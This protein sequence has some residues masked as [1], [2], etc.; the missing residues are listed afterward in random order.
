MPD[1]SNLSVLIIDPNQGMRASLHN[2]LTQ[3]GI[4]K[5]DHAVSSGTAIRQLGKKSYDVIL[6]E[7][8]LSS[9]ADNAGQDG[10]QLLEDLRHHKVIGQW[11]IFI[12]LTSEGV[13]GRVIGAAEL[14]PTDY[15]LKP[16]TVDTLSQRISRALERR[17]TF[18]PIY[19]MIGQGKAREAVTACINAEVAQP[20]YATDYVRL[21]AELLVSMGQVAAAE[22]AYAAVLQNKQLGWAQLG[23]ARCMFQ[24]KRYT[25]AQAALEA[26]LLQNPKFMAAYDL[27]AQVHRALGA[28]EDAKRVLRDAIAISPHMVR[29]LRN[30]GEVALAT[31]DVEGAEKAF[32]QVVAKAKYSEFRDPEDHVNLVKTL[33]TKGDA[34]GAA[35]VVRDLERSMR[36]SPNADVCRAYSAALVQEMNGNAEGAVAE[37]TTA[38]GALGEAKVSSALKLGLAQ[39]CMANELDEQANTLFAGLTSDP[40]SG[41]TDAQIMALCEK[42]GRADMAERYGAKVDSEVDQ[43][44]RK[45][46]EKSRQGDLRGAV[47][48]LQDALRRRPDNTGLWSA[49]ANAILRQ[50][51]DLGW[52]APLAAQ[53]AGLLKRMR[54]HN[55]DHPLLPSLISQYTALRQ[56]YAPQAS[57]NP[58][59]A[60]PAQAAAESR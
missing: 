14:L 58:P 10:Q 2:M 41:V 22:Q 11:A 40:S 49:T 52:D 43:Q 46:A 18:L 45:A 4:S 37:L 20:R 36:A 27:L 6:C 48:V 16:F 1:Y 35:G 3:V 23:Q 21:R 28:D 30:L 47:G 32:K 8:D 44:V 24:L 51:A 33:V 31:G 34:N 29:R 15:I 50:M 57:P 56:K 25:D 17:A 39:T 13:Y 7:Y 42:A 54:E 19:Q 55:P 53:A 59:P 60:A 38:L 9:S 26:L 12:M 5:I